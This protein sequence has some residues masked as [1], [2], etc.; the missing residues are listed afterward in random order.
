MLRNVATLFMMT[1]PSYIAAMHRAAASDQVEVVASVAHALKSSSASLGAMELSRMC[2]KLQQSI[3]LHMRR[4]ELDGDYSREVLEIEAE[5]DRIMPA[6]NT[7][8][9]QEAA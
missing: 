4:G 2:Q 8:V 9:E 1:A 5:F 7:L 6:L 3:R